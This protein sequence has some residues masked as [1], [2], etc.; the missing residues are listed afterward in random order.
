MGLLSK[1][2]N[3]KGAK[4]TNSHSRTNTATSSLVGSDF[5]TTASDSS[6]SSTE[7]PSSTYHDKG[8]NQMQKSPRINDGIPRHLKPSRMNQPVAMRR[9]PPPEG[10]ETSVQSPR[11]PPPTQQQF[12]SNGK[13]QSRINHPTSSSNGAGD[14]PI[15]PLISPKIRKQPSP[16]ANGH[17]KNSSYSKSPLGREQENEEGMNAPY[18]LDPST[19]KPSDVSMRSIS[20]TS[21]GNN[22]TDS[23]FSSSSELDEQDGNNL[24]LSSM[25]PSR[26]QQNS[27]TPQHLPHPVE[28]DTPKSL[29]S[30]SSSANLYQGYAPQQYPQQQPPH[31][32]YPGMGIPPQQHVPGYPQM[33]YF[34]QMYA[35]G[36]GYPGGAPYYGEPQYSAPSTPRIQSRRASTTSLSYTHPDMYGPNPDAMSRKSTITSNR[37]SSAPSFVGKSR[38]TSSYNLNGVTEDK[39]SEEDEEK[40]KSL[41][42]SSGTISQDMS[43]LSLNPTNY[44]YI[45][46]YDRYFF[47]GSDNEDSKQPPE[48]DAKLETSRKSS[49]SSSASYNSIERG[50]S[51]KFKVGSASERLERI[52]TL[53]RS[54]KTSPTKQQAVDEAARRLSRNSR[55]AST[56]VLSSNAQA[57]YDMGSH[58]GSVQDFNSVGY[59]PN[60]MGMMKSQSM[61]PFMM[62]GMSPG[63]Y[64]GGMANYSNEYISAQKR[65]TMGMMDQRRNMMPMGYGQYAQPPMMHYASP[66]GNQSRSTSP[67]RQMMGNSQPHDSILN[68]KIEN[69]ISLRRIIASGNKTLEYRLKWVKMLVNSTNSKLYM[70]INIKGEPINPESIAQ[71]REL[72]IKSSTNHTLKLLRETENK[73]KY[74]EIYSEVCYIYGC[75]LKQDY[76]ELYEQDFNIEK[77]V[78]EALRYFEKS[79]EVR[80][81]N[82]KSFYKLGELYEDELYGKFEPNE[83]EDFIATALNYYKQSAQYGYNKAIFRI[84]L[85]YL[86]NAEHRSPKCIKYLGDLANVD[87]NS[88]EIQLEDDDRDELDHVIGNAA[89]QMGRIYEGLYPGEL[90]SESEFVIKC[91]QMAPVNWGKA[92]TYYNKA[93][94]LNCI[95]AQ[96]RLAKVYENGE[97]DR[98]QNPN[99]SIQWFMKASSS[100]ISSMRN[101]EAM[102]GLSRWYMKGSNG[103]NRSIP[104]PD[105]PK[106]LLWCERA[107]ASNSADAFFARGLLAEQGL[108]IEP[109]QQFFEAAYELG[110]Q[111]AGQRLGLVSDDEPEEPIPEESYEYDLQEEFKVDESISTPHLSTQQLD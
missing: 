24:T 22:T 84:S 38:A 102:L 20:N 110:H 4:R 72:F 25:D 57:P 35:Q 1:F 66:M 106:A 26:I 39:L 83:G 87:T 111:I 68:K 34:N 49:T 98:Q 30:R 50:S 40:K 18:S 107:L 78:D 82:F 44:R 14:Y 74:E 7:T 77:N 53:S 71:H 73:E 70:Y 52:Q 13:F 54:N 104:Y 62:A 41:K 31:G 105:P 33:P 3:D 5:S 51:G 103:L 29:S 91:L 21:F 11:T 2:R 101:Y 109:A 42:S 65:H 69:Y 45:S 43:D 90:T 86:N 23:T 93:A 55:R 19:G 76:V 61:E 58:A 79:I 88:K 47:D 28:S 37:H 10:V 36:A 63:M 85:L 108:G 46:D 9:K 67:H 99:K 48:E 100:P 64:N 12:Q 94:R 60:R 27:Y 96:V 97:L 16:P 56:S 92:L 81:N 95:L 89:F 6:H 32:Y 15:N 80:G 17:S 75:F 59:P 8:L